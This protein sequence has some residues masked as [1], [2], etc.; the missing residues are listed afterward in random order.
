MWYYIPL[1]FVAV[2]TSFAAEAIRVDGLQ[3]A[4]GGIFNFGGNE[5]Q[6]KHFDPVWKASVQSQLI[7]EPGFPKVTGDEWELQGK[8]PVE[9]AASPL[10]L[11]EKL[12]RVDDNSFRVSYLA[13]HPNGLPTK[14]LSLTVEIP[15]DLGA[16]QTVTLD[17]TASVLPAQFRDVVVLTNPRVRSITLP[18][19]NGDIMITSD[20][21]TMMNVL[22]QD[23]RKFGADTF[24]IRLQFVLNAELMTKGTLAATIRRAHF[25]STS[26]SLRNVANR[27]LRDEIAGDRQGGWTDQGPENDM[28]PL[29]PGPVTAAGVSFDVLDPANNDG[30]SAVVLGNTDQ[31]ELPRSVSVPMRGIGIVSPGWLYLLH[32]TAWSPA[33][34]LQVGTI[35]VKYADGSREAFPIISGRD[36]SD[37]WKLDS[38]ENARV[39]WSGQNFSSMVGLYVSRFRLARKPVVEVQL[40]GAGKAVWMIAGMSAS[41]EEIR[42]VSMP[43]EF[44]ANSD[45]ASHD[46]KLEV[47]AGSVFDFSSLTEAPAGRHGPLIATP[48][49]HFEFQAR[50]G[51]RVRF[52]G[53]NLCFGANFLDK[54][55]AEQ[56]AERLAR[57]GYNAVRFHHFDGQLIRPGT[58]SW[59]ID[60]DEL[61]KLDY[62]FACLKKRGIYINIDL[63]TF[64]PFSDD[65]FKS[66][67]FGS[68]VIKIEDQR[69]WFKAIMPISDNAFESWSKYAKKLLTHRN[70]YT[71]TSWADDPA[72]IGICPVNEDTITMLNNRPQ[73]LAAYESLLPRWKAENPK[74]PLM[75]PEEEFNLFLQIKQKESD[76]RMADFLHSLKVNALISGTNW[77]CNLPQS[78]LR[79]QYDYVDDHAYQDHPSFPKVQWALPYSFK[80]SDA[81][82]NFASVPREMFPSRV[83]GKPFT[84]TEYNYAQ[85]NRFRAQG[86]VLMPAYAGLQDWDAIYN[87]DYASA[88]S[89]LKQ[90]SPAQAFSIATDPIGM[91]ADRVSALL[92]RRGDV[93]P[94]ESGV[95]FAADST[96]S[97]GS[98]KGRWP[99]V[100]MDFS[101]LGLITRVGTMWESANEFVAGPTLGVEFED[102]Y[103]GSTLEDSR[104]KR[105]KSLV[106]KQNIVAVVST[107]GQNDGEGLYQAGDRLV[108]RVVKDRLKA[109]AA[110]D[111]VAKRF[112]SETGQIELF[113][114]TGALKMVTP[115]SE[116]FI[117]PPGQEFTGDRVQI[118]NGEAYGAVVVTAVDDK[119]IAESQRLLVVHLTNSVNTGMRFADEDL[120]LLEDIGRLPHLIRRGTVDIDLRLRRDGN[121]RAYAVDATGLRKE[122][123]T[124][125]A[126]RELDQLRLSAST[127]NASRKTT[128]AYEL[129]F[130]AVAPR[131]ISS[132]PRAVPVTPGAADE[133]TSSPSRALP[134]GPSSPPNY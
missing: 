74:L 46:H 43:V 44:G 81:V 128:L 24:S 59:L 64:R 119:P 57:S 129:V 10:T 19:R 91:L 38:R 39:G 45:W 76:A 25:T 67:G 28:S 12:K 104:G 50:P 29:K 72:L 21:G 69:S 117:L 96:A 40:E 92:F 20:V 63:Y 27:A 89:T 18:A 37:W 4:P 65:E 9:G 130:V 80:Q 41:M 70:P 75:S 33:P 122:D 16:S 14:S 54:K 120:R 8:V 83:F 107:D 5:F 49:G 35:S 102:V 82:K 15:I 100:P 78:L 85:P 13:T 110:G 22:V 53:V 30:K 90:S 97:F 66:F 131:P 134:I 88:A 47:R 2:A 17:N 103:G 98:D 111:L 86:M 58:P 56:L 51:K 71:G 34:G 52:W 1:L 32:A 112:V 62:L 116:G 106:T 105:L 95:I 68:G 77:G 79:S 31:P 125:T 61:D 108:E 48:E 94:A 121:W 101:H 6:V 26:V 84:C 123:I 113:G 60:M 115:R 109:P 118:K 73:M 36:V 114:Q 124:L 126:G 133:E 7:P 132:V 42:T 3:T 93:K 87:F 127:V 55:Q 11:T 99:R 23:D